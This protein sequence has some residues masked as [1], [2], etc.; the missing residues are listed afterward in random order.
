MQVSQKQ[1]HCLLKKPSCIILGHIKLNDE[2]HLLSFCSLNIV[3]ISKL[4]LSKFVN[5]HHFQK[6][7]AGAPFGMSAYLATVL[8]ASRRR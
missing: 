2:F 4:N 6:W 8:A 1:G 5:N 7:Q 3:P